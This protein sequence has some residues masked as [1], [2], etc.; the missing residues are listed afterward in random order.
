MLG[1]ELVLEGICLGV[2]G[3]GLGVRIAKRSGM[4]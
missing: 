1:V 2:W 4:E 3:F